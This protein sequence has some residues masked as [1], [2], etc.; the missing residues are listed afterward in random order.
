MGQGMPGRLWYPLCLVSCDLC[1]S[2]QAPAA[3]GPCAGEGGSF[4]QVGRRLEKG[5]MKGG[6]GLCPTWALQTLAGAVASVVAARMTLVTPWTSPLLLSSAFLPG[7]S[8]LCRGFC[9]VN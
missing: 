3:P 7:R 2:R 9:Y 1:P 8:V 6:G 4:L 5:E